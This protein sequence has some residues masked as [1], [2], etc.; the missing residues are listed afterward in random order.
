M[1]AYYLEMSQ[2]LGEHPVIREKEAYKIKYIN[3]LEYF[4]RKYS[5]NDIWATA[6]LRLYAE[7]LLNNPAEYKYTLTD[8][9]KQSKGVVATK[10]RPFQFFSYRYC[11]LIDCIFINAHGD[12]KL[13]E[14]IF[15]EISCIYRKRYHT[16]IHQL[17]EFLYNPVISVEFEKNDYMKECWKCNHSFL[18]TKPIKVLVTA[19]MSAGKSTLLNALVG[20]KVNKVQNDACTAKIHYIKNKPYEDS[21]CYEFDYQLDLDADY[22]TLMDDNSNNSTNVITVGTYFRTVG[23]AFKRVWLIDTPGVNYS[24][25]GWH[26][27][28]AEDT[29]KS[30]EADL[31]IYLLNSENIGTYDEYK[32]LVFILEHYHGNI[33]F[34]VNKVDRFRKNEDSVQETLRTVTKELIALG[35]TDPVVVPVS[36]YAAYLAKMKIYGESLDEDEQDEFNRMARKLKKIEYQFNTYYP[37]KYQKAIHV[38]CDTE[39]SLLLLHSGILQLEQIINTTR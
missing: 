20:K 39:E 18:E 25:D 38:S 29:I 27:K 16:N 21:L 17:F 13:G 12:R 6:V 4:V 5:K 30:A 7:K 35:Y 31:L 32:H 8:F 1:E 33:L 24:R 36:A 26:K 3:V 22:R 2:M 23:K 15:Q 10:F 11:L 14:K 28:L 19:N 9:A 37:E 34:V